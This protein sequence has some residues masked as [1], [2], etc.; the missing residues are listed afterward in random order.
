MNMLYTHILAHPYYHT[1]SVL[2]KQATNLASIVWALV[3]LTNENALGPTAYGSLTHCIHEDA[4]AGILLIVSFVQATWLV[5]KL[6]PMSYGLIGYAFQSAWWIAA[7]TMV[8]L[9]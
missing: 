5:L 8:I 6:R 9:H 2:A 4:I 7:A 3:V 1:G